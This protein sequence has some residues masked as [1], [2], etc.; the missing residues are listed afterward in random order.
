MM[1]CVPIESSVKRTPT[2]KV[3]GVVG[4]AKSST[5]APPSVCVMTFRKIVSAAVSGLTTLVSSSV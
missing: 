5:S 1:I 2:P 3:K 4:H